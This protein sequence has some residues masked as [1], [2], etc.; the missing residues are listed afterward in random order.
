MTNSKHTKRALLSSVVALLLCFTML[1]G[2][3]FAWFTDNVSSTGNRIQS[4]NLDVDL[5]MY[6]DGAYTSIAG[7]SGDIFSE[8][9]DGFWEPG[10]T[11]IVY[12]GVENEGNLALKYN[13]ILDI[14]DG[15]LIGS[16]EYAIID[17][18]EAGD[19]DSISNWE[20]LKTYA[21]GQTG[22]V[23]AGKI[24]AAQGGVLDEIVNG[25]ANETDYFALAVHMKESATNEFE[26]KNIT[27]DVNVIATQKGAEEDSFGPEYD[28]DATYTDVVVND[29]ASLE[30]AIANGET[31]IGLNGT[32][33]LA[34]S[35]GANGVTFVGT[36]KG[37]AI[38]F[39]TYGISGT[40]NTF[41]NLT[42]DNERN[43]WYNGMQYSDAENTTYIN[44]TI[45]NGLTTY[46][47][48]TFDRCV[49][50]ELPAGNYSLFIYDGNNIT[51]KNSTFE[52]GDRAI[53]IYNEGGCKDISVDISNS[54]FLLT[55]T[56][57]L[58][59]ALI[60][61]DDEYLDSVKVDIKN[62]SVDG[63]LK[64]Q[65]IYR[66]NDGALDTSTAKSVV[67][68]DG[69]T[70]TV[71]PDTLTAAIAAAEGAD[72]V[73]V[74][75]NGTYDDDYKIT[76]AAQG[77]AKGDIVFKAAE[78]SEVVFTGTTTL[79]YR[80]QGTGATMWDGNITFENVTFHAEAG[81]HSL[82]IQDVKSITLK[83]CT[84]IG[85]GEMGI[86]SARGNATGPSKIIGCT[87][88]NA[89]MQVLGNFGTGLV[90]DDCDFKNSNVNVQAG[91]GVT[92]Q[93]CRF[94]ATLTDANIGDSFYLVRSN[95]IPI[96]ITNCT[97]DVDSAVTGV[98][99]AQSKWGIFWNRGTTNWT[100]SD[101][102]VNL[103]DAAKTQTELLVTKCTSTGAIN[104]SNLTIN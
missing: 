70:N 99:S 74:L 53:K 8:A 55:D 38:D 37:A 77:Q 83:N 101:V 84:I 6:K 13:I 82:D 5:V 61:I 88:E 33:T 21:N 2:A 24:V 85:D 86:T 45:A 76:V 57:V 72:N 26:N 98:A 73:F 91:N 104:T 50:K 16:L 1:M 64:A 32:I 96:T 41:K 11:Q 103:T 20:D 30:A 79:G 48:S 69:V 58:K 66:I 54:T 15:G 59:K 75:S 4:G 95:A 97:V 27:I 35:L 100:V 87:F 102:T 3:T 90:I 42:L 92:I 40:G 19:L 9:G 22:D 14:I 60:E 31:L 44:C 51:V 28:E 49:F 93:N 94:D 23:T 63:G 18:A 67:T 47:S 29:A 46:G 89:P 12:L 80:E 25:I 34:K 17:K 68:V 7:N 65:G 78:G 52:Y 81:K 56:S 71:T 10:K 62:I 39:G 36:S 43:G